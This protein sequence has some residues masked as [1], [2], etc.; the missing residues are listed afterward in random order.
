M[1]FLSTL[2][3]DTVAWDLCVDSSNDI[4]VA[5]DPYSGAQ[6]AASACKLWLG[7]YWYDTTVG[8]PY[9]SIFGVTPVPA[10]FIKSELV[11]AALTVPNATSAAVFISSISPTTRGLIGQVQM[12]EDDAVVSIAEFGIGV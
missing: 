8:V 12:K 11:D 2:L 9:L 1:A 6:D 5:S 10:S 7:E 3:L 4:A